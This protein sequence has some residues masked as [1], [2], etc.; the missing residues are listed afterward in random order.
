MVN[1]WIFDLQ[2]LL[3]CTEDSATQGA[4]HTDVGRI[5]QTRC[6]LCGPSKGFLVGSKQLAGRRPSRSQCRSFQQIAAVAAAPTLEQGADVGKVPPFEA[7]NTGAKIKKREDIKTILL[8]GAG[9]IIIGQVCRC[10]VNMGPA[11]S[12]SPMLTFAGQP[13]AAALMAMLHAAGL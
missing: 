7:W 13:Q 6:P 9:P 5:H 1:S 8:L 11:P 3:R 10:P 4:M 2:I 12:R